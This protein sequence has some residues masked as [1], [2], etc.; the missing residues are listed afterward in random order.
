MEDLEEEEGAAKVDKKDVPLK[1]DFPDLTQKL[2][3]SDDVIEQLVFCKYVGDQIQQSY[4]VLLFF[5]VS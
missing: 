5:S 1:P 2:A 3:D 4:C